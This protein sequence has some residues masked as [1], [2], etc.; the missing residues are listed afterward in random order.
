M[1]GAVAPA[2]EPP[3]DSP[4][5][6]R[7]RPG[8]AISGCGCLVVLIL[9]IAVHSLVFRTC[10][11]HT[12]GR[13]IRAG[14]SPAEVLDQTSPGFIACRGQKVGP[15]GEEHWLTIRP[16]GVIVDGTA[17]D[18][19]HKIPEALGREIEARM[20]ASPGDSFVLTFVFL[21]DF[22]PRT[23]LPVEFGPDARVRRVHPIVYGPK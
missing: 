17:E 10:L 2:A 18:G 12:R 20:K 15:Q 21:T 22:P 4:P 3:P 14:M 11:V 13:S 19:P 7:R 1:N 6:V 9:A 8:C 5:P 16:D 23:S